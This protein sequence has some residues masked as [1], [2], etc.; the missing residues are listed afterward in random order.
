MKKTTYTK[1]RVEGLTGPA[2]EAMAGYM[3]RD[4]SPNE[5]VKIRFPN[6]IVLSLVWGLGSYATADTVE[7]AVFPEDMHK[8]WLT[9]K[10]AKKLFN[11]DI[12]DDVDGYC[13]AERVHAYFVGVQN[14]REAT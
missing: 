10:V 11:E 13:D 2:L 5:G 1:R 14:M 12:G 4:T 3:G 9:Q 8:K 6:G 7:L